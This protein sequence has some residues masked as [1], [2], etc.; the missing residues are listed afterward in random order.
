ML[1]CPPHEGEIRQDPSDK[2]FK[3]WRAEENELT[4][5][6]QWKAG[7]ITRAPNLEPGPTQIKFYTGTKA[8]KITKDHEEEFVVPIHRIR[9]L[10]FYKALMGSQPDMWHDTVRSFLKALPAFGTGASAPVKTRAGG[11]YV[12]EASLGAEIVRVNDIIRVNR[13]GQAVNT[14]LKVK[15]I[16]VNAVDA[17]PTIVTHY[18]GLAY[19]TLK[20]QGRVVKNPPAIL[21]GYG[22]W[23]HYAKPGEYT[24]VTAKAAISRLYEAEALMDMFPVL[25]KEKLLDLGRADMIDGRKHAK[26]MKKGEFNPSARI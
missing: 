19:T 18:R 12:H 5:Y 2:G 10:A 25:S 4:G 14:V 8:Q 16:V 1:F 22:P 11:Y 7:I 9:P 20:S 6:P 26:Q 13:K 21:R 17:K 24:T 3:I 23:Y 15:R